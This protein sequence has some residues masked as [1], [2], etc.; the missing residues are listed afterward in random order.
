MPFLDWTNAE[1]GRV[2]LIWLALAIV[3]GL[4]VLEL[5]RRDA[6][7]AFL[8][9]VMQ[10][11]LTAH[12]GMGRVIAR[13]V[14]VLLALVFGVFAAMRPQA[15]GETEV[16]GVGASA[17]VMFVLDT[18]RSM[19]AEDASPNRL[20][21]AKAEIG[22]L[23]DKLGPQR[24][25]LVAFAGRPVLVCPLTPD[26]SFFA[27]VLSTIDTRSAGRGGSRVGDALKGALRGFP[28]GQGARL[29]V[30]ITDGDDQDQ[31]TEEAAKLVRDASVKIV[32]V[33]LGSE[34]GSEITLTDPQTGARTKL[35]D[36]TG[37]P[38]IS[39]LDGD[40]L[41]KIALLTE[42]AYVPAGTSAVDL[43]AIM[44]SH[45]APLVKQAS[46][47]AV[48]V[49]PAERYIWMVLA[50]LACLLA[51]LWIGAGAGRREAPGGQP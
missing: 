51:S 36:K 17:D 23:V 33:G 28:P 14:L 31:Y 27:T 30:L 32:A 19:L 26:H 10:R 49:V 25:G 46:A 50:S 44:E 5:R 8:S 34:T 7:D 38:V 40:K 13:L 15:R 37:T 43:G 47:G 11:R 6:M 45:I 41:R 24:V 1:P 4:V 39:K 20:A 12:A 29:I 42:G 21:R 16:V 9:P 18:S 3:G 48:R 22:Q 35:L 2:H